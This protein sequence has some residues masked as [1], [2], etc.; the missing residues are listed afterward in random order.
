[1]SWQTYVNKPVLQA[2]G[3][4]EVSMRAHVH[5]W[6]CVCVHPW[7]YARA[8]VCAWACVLACICTLHECV[9]EESG[10]M[11]HGE[12]HILC[13]NTAPLL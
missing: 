13:A 5:V 12:H 10:S 11:E 8:R 1:V 2:N 7:I 4:D 9:C 6:V 3:I